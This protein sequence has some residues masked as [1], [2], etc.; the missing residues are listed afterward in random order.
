MVFFLGHAHPSGDAMSKLMKSVFAAAAV[1][2]LCASPASALPQD[3]D[4]VCDCFTPCNIVCALPGSMKVVRCG[5]WD[6]TCGSC[7]NPLDP[8]AS[9]KTEKDARAEEQVCRE[10]QKDAQG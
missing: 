10:P 5:Q 4:E 3:C 9:V 6:E 2:V 7:L 1:L 8:E